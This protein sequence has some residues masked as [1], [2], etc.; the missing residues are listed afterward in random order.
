MLQIDINTGAAAVYAARLE[1]AGRSKLPVA[2]RQTLSA[3]A[4]DVKKVTMPKTSDK[5]FK[6]RKPTFFKATS[7]V[8]KASGFDINNMRSKVGFF[9]PTNKLNS[10]H[11]A[12]DLQEQEYGGKIDKRAYIP[13]KPARTA[14]GNVKEA[15]TLAKLNPIVKDA[16]KFAGK[17]PRQKWNA[18]ATAVGVGGFVIG[19]LKNRSGSRMLWQIKDIS[20]YSVISASGTVGYTFIKAE[21]LYSIEGKRKVSVKPTRFMAKASEQSAAKMAQIFT[22]IAEKALQAP[23]PNTR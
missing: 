7:T 11:A 20:R 16:N 10:G 3:V 13:M 15:Y 12:Q 1:Q 18:A 23:P 4:F 22:D 19:T 8:E 2:V 9:A 17:S 5:A 6:K 14:R 21:P